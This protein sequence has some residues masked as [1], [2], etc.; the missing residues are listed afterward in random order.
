M[1]LPNKLFSYNQ[2]IFSKFPVVLTELK[3]R[4]MSVHEL[5][6]KVIRKMSG[7]NEFVETLDCLYAL[8]KIDYDEERE[9]LQYVIRN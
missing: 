3:S 6:K 2:S 5:Y 7:V 9:V 8:G 4:P 1:L